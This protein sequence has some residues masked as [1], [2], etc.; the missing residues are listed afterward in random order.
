LNQNG[1]NVEQI[2]KHT[3]YNPINQLPTG[4]KQQTGNTSYVSDLLDYETFGANETIIIQSCTGTGKT[5]AIAKHMSYL[6]PKFGKGFCV[7]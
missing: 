1:G 4:W 3:K 2:P 7:T 5:T 6:Q